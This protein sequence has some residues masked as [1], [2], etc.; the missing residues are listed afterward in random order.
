[1]LILWHVFQWVH[2]C[3][4]FY[5]PSLEQLV[6]DAEKWQSAL[7]YSIDSQN[8]KIIDQVYL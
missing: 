3:Y 6:V 2:S 4:N 8:A 7:S 5:S 1:M